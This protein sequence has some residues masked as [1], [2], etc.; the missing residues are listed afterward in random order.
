ME[1]SKKLPEMKEFIDKLS[2]NF[3][4]RKRT[5]S[6]EREVCVSCGKEAKEFRDKLS[7]KEYTISGLCQACQDLTFMGG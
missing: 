3:F 7:E 6:I 2:S 5:D 4:G 1:P